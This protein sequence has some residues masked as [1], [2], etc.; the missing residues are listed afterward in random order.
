MKFIVLLSLCMLISCKERETVTE[1]PKPLQTYSDGGISVRSYNFD[2]LEHKLHREGDSTYVVNFWATWCQPCI[3]ELPH[4]ER[5]HSEYSDEKVKVLLVSMDMT[6]QVES[7]LIPYID[8]NNLKS[9]VVHLS[10]PDA[11]SWIN[12]VDSTWSGA[13]PATLIYNR[14]KR[15]FY[16]KS[17]TYPELQSEINKFK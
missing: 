14:S 4:F 6:K 8:K 16:E 10:D 7:R 15:Q 1:D 17:F 3:E 11:D 2:G 13:I 5:L 12:K 9:E